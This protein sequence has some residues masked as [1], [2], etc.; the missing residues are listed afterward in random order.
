MSLE[1]QRGRVDE[2]EEVLLSVTRHPSGVITFE[3][4]ED[5]AV[6]RA[7]I[8]TA[9]EFL[10]SEE[11]LPLSLRMQAIGLAMALRGWTPPTPHDPAATMSAVGIDDACDSCGQR[12]DRGISFG[13]DRPVICG[14]CV[15]LAAGLLARGPG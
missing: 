1:G 8:A 7:A 6:L 14:D 15:R 2:K 10:M 9:C 12:G 5:L 4:H 3:G 13:P 11:E